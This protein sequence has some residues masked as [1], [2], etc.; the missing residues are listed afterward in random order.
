VEVV[1]LA[2]EQ[3]Q[4]SLV[5]ISFSRDPHGNALLF[6]REPLLENAAE[7]MAAVMEADPQVE[8]EGT[9]ARPYHGSRLYVRTPVTLGFAHLPP[10]SVGV[11]LTGAAI[12]FVSRR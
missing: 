11:E 5:G 3:L 2:P 7:A 8:S 6:V 1:D 10:G 9:L 4:A 12:R